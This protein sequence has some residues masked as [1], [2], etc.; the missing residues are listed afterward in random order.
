MDELEAV[1]KTPLLESIGPPKILQYVP[2][3]RKE[4]ATPS[5]LEKADTDKSDAR[6]DINAYMQSFNINIKGN[7]KCEF[8]NNL[9]L[10]WPSL[11][12]QERKFPDDVI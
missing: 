1:T 2:E 7:A 11:D 5:Q 6:S 8:C 9:T 4:Q 10:A 12:D 3:S